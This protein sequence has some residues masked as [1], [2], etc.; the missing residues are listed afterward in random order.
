[1]ERKAVEDLEDAAVVKSE[2]RN[3]ESIEDSLS[4]S[5]E[6]TS[7]ILRLCRGTCTIKLSISAHSKQW[8]RRR[9]IRETKREGINNTNLSERPCSPP[10]YAP[11]QLSGLKLVGYIC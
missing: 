7:T 10:L 6:L 9:H 11:V 4:Q 8:R 3:M 1:M 2:L 5:I